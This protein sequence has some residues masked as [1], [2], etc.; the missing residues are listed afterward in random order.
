MDAHIPGDRRRALT[1]G[2]VIPDRTE[3][4]VLFADISGFTPLTEALARE[5]GAHR[6]PEEL[7]LVLE[8]VYDAVLTELHRYGGVV[9]YFSG[10]AVTCWFDHDDGSLAVGCGLA[11]QEAMARVSTITTPGGTAVQLGMKVA[12]AAGPARRF[13]VGD[14]DI[15][16]IDAIGGSLLDRVADLEHHAERGEV[17][18][19]ARTLEALGPRVDVIE[20]GEDGTRVCVVVALRGE[21]LLPK[22]PPPPRRLPRSVARQWVLPAVY[23]RLATGRGEFLAELRPVMSMF[24]RFGGF[25]FDGD[26]AAPRRLDDFLR[27]VQRI[28]NA[29]GGSVLNLTIGDKGAYLYAVFGAPLAHE[30]D[31]RRACSAAFAVLGLDGVSAA[32]GLQVG[33][34]RGSLFSGMYGHRHRCTF[35]CLGD[36]TN[37][38]ARLMSAAPAGEAYVAAEVADEVSGGFAFE[39]LPPLTVKGKSA[40]VAVSRLVGVQGGLLERRRSLGDQFMGRERELA[41][42]LELGDQ[43]RSG[44]LHVAAVVAEAGLGKSTLAEHAARQLT[45]R[46]MQ[47]YA[48]AAASIGAESYL[49]WRGV[50]SALFGLSRDGDAAT[51][52]HEALAETD[53]DLLPRL[54]LLGAVLGV[55][56]ED[57][58]LTRGFDAKLR[59]SSLESLLLRYVRARFATQPMVLWLE[60]CHWIDSLS[61]DLLEVLVRGLPDLP[62]L[63]LLTYRVGS[64]TAPKSPRTT[65]TEL[66]RLD[67]AACDA[68]LRVRLAELYGADAVPPAEL[69]ARLVERAGG[70]PFYLGELANYLA[71]RRVDLADPGAGATELPVSLSTLVLA[72]VDALAES[73]RR[74]LKVASVVGR[75]FATDD[76]VGAYPDLGS[77]KQVTGYIGRLCGEDLVVEENSATGDYAFKHAVIREVTYD[78]M[79]YGMRARLHD[80]VGTWLERT[81]PDAIDLLA[82]HFWHGTDD[83]KRRDYL[84][85]AGD[86]AQARFANDAAVDYFRRVAPLVDDAERISV[87]MKLGAVLGL[88][89]EWAESEAVLGE[90]MV[91]AD[92]LGE[93]IAGARARM[94]RADAIR[95]QGRFDE[96][97]RELDEAGRRCE[98][99]A[100]DVGLGR[101]LHLQ[102][103]IAAQQGDYLRSRE[104]YDRSLEIRVR[105][106]DRQAE[107]ALLSNLALVAEYEEDYERC[108]ELNERALELRYQVG[109]N[110]GIGVSL[111][112]LGHAEYLEGAFAPARTHLEEA[113]RVELEVGDPWMVAMARHTLG[114]VARELGDPSA[115]RRHY[116]D[117]LRTFVFSGDKWSQCPILEDVA[118]LVAPDDPGA[119]LT[120]I[121]AAEAMRGAIGAARPAQQ[122]KML[123]DLFRAADL[124]PLDRETELARGRALGADAAAELAL[125]LCG[126][127]VGS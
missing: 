89:G 4:A 102:G 100:D 48:G 59:K 97:S 39:P 109:D 10:D 2:A 3:G 7:S 28:V 127:A 78:S 82:H 13:V 61:S 92:T 9:I 95:K 111:N 77:K 85:R 96:A 90:A 26:D 14:P 117:A 98:A 84:L 76:V 53:P 16:L 17:L 101:V 83:G 19:D 1:T 23:E 63:V 73:P 24:V 122:A 120:L 32:S 68:L 126:T 112:N 52:L 108:R 46:G 50:F 124:G 87:L 65:V 27:Q 6:G 70:N 42:L 118:V 69:V 11:M 125:T 107:A 94:E 58:D 41:G 35:T 86:A 62:I 79:P 34:S 113:I 74:T 91:L 75:E 99:S 81:A 37:L 18:V 25:D 106:G 47:V 49:V 31:A 121:G 22:P 55:H 115:A 57:N 44:H 43:A 51:E 21:Q 110:W 105:L 114:H 56:L 67:E 66:E 20:R 104:R 103:T 88:S 36:A 30:D 33:V 119:A 72:R 60:D 71:S 38:A 15:Q 12:V 5:V 29:S 40:P 8:S 64:F 123:E 80:N 93:L 54:P 116:G 45:E